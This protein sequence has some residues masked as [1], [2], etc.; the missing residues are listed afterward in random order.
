MRR[1]IPD[2][3]CLRSLLAASLLT[4][5]MYPQALAQALTPQAL[6]QALAQQQSARAKF[7]ERKFIGFVDQPIESRGELSFT[8]PDRLE[9][10]TLEPRQESLVLE[11]ETLQVEQAGK[12]RMT[13]SL[14]SHPEAAAFVESIRGTLAGDLVTLQKYYTLELSGSLE[15]W[16]LVLVPLQARMQKIVTRIRIEGT[17]SSV[18]SIGFDQADGDR[19]EMQITPSPVP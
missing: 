10:R 6:M 17:A 19:S 1:F 16:K 14:P 2:P 3:K 18:R 7:V 4:L 15:R 5:G 11:G 9:K 8:A 13:V 12:R